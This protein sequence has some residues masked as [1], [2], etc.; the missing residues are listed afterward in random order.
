[1]KTS[2]TRTQLVGALIWAFASIASASPSVSRDQHFTPVSPSFDK[3]S[4]SAAG[5]DFNQ[6][7]VRDDVE[8]FL[9]ANAK[10]PK[11]L[12]AY[13][14]LAKQLERIIVEAPTGKTSAT[15]ISKDIESAMLN[16]GK[17][18]AFFTEAPIK[19]G[20][21]EELVF[22]TKERKSAYETFTTAFYRGE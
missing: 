21:L 19:I 1:M 2:R 15:S 16:L 5:E 22:N 12:E 9:K 4:A 8:L 20:Q 17:V 11:V 18:T 3:V 13:R 14:E 7:G 6:D 10:P